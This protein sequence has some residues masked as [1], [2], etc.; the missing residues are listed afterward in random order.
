MPK[1]LNGLLTNP[2]SLRNPKAPVS[3]TKT[4]RKYCRFYAGYTLA[5]GFSR[6]TDSITLPDHPHVQNV[7]TLILQCRLL[8]ILADTSLW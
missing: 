5:A 7:T 4:L 3:E 1:P 8:R 2:E 6:F